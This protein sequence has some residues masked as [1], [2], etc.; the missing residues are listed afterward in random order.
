M[1]GIDLKHLFKRIEES[2]VALV[3]FSDWYTESKWCLD[4]LV[5]INERMIEGKLKVIPIFYKVTV[6]NVKKLEGKFGT[7][8][9]E[10][11]RK[12]QGE[13]DRIRDWEEALKSI[14]QKFGLPSSEY[15]TEYDL[16][17]A[18]VVEVKR[19]LNH[20]PMEEAAAT[21][22]DRHRKEKQV[23][24]Q[25]KQGVIV[26]NTK[27]P[28]K[29]SNFT[30]TRIRKM[31]IQRSSEMLRNEDEDN[32]PLAR[33]KV[34]KLNIEEMKKKRKS[35]VEEKPMEEKWK[36]EDCAQPI[37]ELIRF[38][39]KEE[40]MKCHYEKFEFHG[41]QYGLEDSVL[42]IPEAPTRKL[43]PAIIKDI[44]KQGKEGYVYLE[45][46]WFYRPEEA[47]I[48][49]GE[50]WESRDSRHLFYSFHRDEVFAESVKR[51]CLIYFVPCEKQIPKQPGFIVQNVYDN[52]NKK[53]WKLTDNDFKE[54]QKHEI[55]LL[56]AKTMSQLGDFL[57]IEK[58]QKTLKLKGK[59]STPKRRRFFSKG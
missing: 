24:T 57:D 45:V 1:R 22:M 41:K 16:V 19:L 27:V 28:N 44:Y 56:V 10:T 18:I 15:R 58:E 52:V 46:Q 39:G 48:K 49:Y 30:I 47:E 32:V 8:F 13:L 40:D 2:S 54:K 20:V 42:L 5:K 43:Y 55:D 14:P 31:L 51:K 6:Y 34:R 37:G 21:K 12:Y 23:P 53:L 9:R 7:K 11:K 38:T 59:R 3:I 4:E 17:N 36:Q 26:Y 50:S 29:I 25:T 33:S 35:D